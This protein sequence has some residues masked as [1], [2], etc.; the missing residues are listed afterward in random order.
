MTIAVISDTHIGDNSSKLVDG[1]GVF[2]PASTAY[3]KFRDGIR[4]FTSGKPLEFLVL[5]GDIMDFSINSISSSISEARPFFNQLSVDKIAHRVIYIPGNHDKQV[6]DGLQWDTSVTGNLFDY[7][8]PK[9]FARTQPAVINCKGGIRLDG[10]NPH[11]DGKYGN[12]FLK[13]LFSRSSDNPDIILAYPNLYIERNG[14]TIIT[15][16]GHMFETAWVLLSD[17]FRGVAGL[18]EYPDLKELEEWNVPLTSMICTGVGSGGK[19]SELLYRIEREVYENKTGTLSYVLDKVLPRLK[20][21]M[22]LPWYK[23]ILIPDWLIKRIILSAT[24]D[25]ENPREYENYLDDENKAKHFAIFLKA[26]VEELIRLKLPASK[27]VIFGH[28]H[29]PYGCSKPY[30]SKKFPAFKFYNTGGWL[31]ESTAEVFLLDDERFES[32]SVK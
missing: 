23:K 28:T 8:D 11:V 14:E 17:M 7:R 4:N 1:K 12:I 29:F 26:T 27:T 18:H 25:T 21:E 16:H 32:F 2:N 10:I 3:M 6:W 20:D 5:C 19:V 31:A 13:G 22:G 30:E 9:P 24:H 15:T